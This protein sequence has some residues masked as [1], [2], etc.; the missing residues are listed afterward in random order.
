[1]GGLGKY[2]NMNKR[3]RKKRDKKV[4]VKS[5]KLFKQNRKLDPLY[6]WKWTILPKEYE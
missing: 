5:R 4:L 1:M 6:P 3:Q 2:E